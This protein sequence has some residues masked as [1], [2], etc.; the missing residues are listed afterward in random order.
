MTHYRGTTW[1]LFYHTHSRLAIRWH[2]RTILYLIYLYIYIVCVRVCESIIPSTLQHI[3]TC[4]SVE[5]TFSKFDHEI[6]FSPYCRF[7]EWSMTYG[8]LYGI[9]LSS[10]YSWHYRKLFK[11]LLLLLGQFFVYCFFFSVWFVY[12]R[13]ICLHCLC[14]W[15]HRSNDLL[16]R[17]Y[18]YYY[19]D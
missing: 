17:F 2:Y 6:W 18:Y 16:E 1:N 12:K 7:N 15:C 13:C 10:T 4:D 8:Q 3:N 19:F 11:A 9:W 14:V 5:F